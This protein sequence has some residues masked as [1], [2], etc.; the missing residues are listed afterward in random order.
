MKLSIIVPVYN[1]EKYII[2]CLDSLYTGEIEDFEVICV[3]DRGQDLSITKIKEYVETNNIKNLRIIENSCN[4]GL[5][6]SR[7]VGIKVAKGDYVAFVDSDD[8]VIAANLNKLLNHAIKNDLDII[9]G[10]IEEKL[11]CDSNI[12]LGSSLKTRSDS[13]IL[14]GEQYFVKVNNEGTYR[15]MVWSRIYNRRLFNNEIHFFVP[16]LKFEDEEFSP[17]IIISAKKVQFLNLNLYIYRRRNESIT[18]NMFNDKK[19]IQHYLTI[20]ESLSKFSSSITNSQVKASIINLNSNIALSIIKNPLAYN[21]NADTLEYALEVIK[22]HKIYN[23]PIKSKKISI[24][25]QGIIMR[26]PWLFIK[27]YKL[28]GIVTK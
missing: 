15:A 9:E 27:T 11:E 20:I 3:D 24:K 25:I 28:K 22:E 6:E 2:E 5:S 16:G 23:I 14:T 10:E 7:N 21:A 26:Y 17:R 18:T 1:V 19:W 12:S 13:E 8:M 4:K